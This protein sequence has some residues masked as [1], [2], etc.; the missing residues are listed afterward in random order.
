MEELRNWLG[1]RGLDAEAVNT[2]RR[3]HDQ[4]L[5][6]IENEHQF[7]SHLQVT[8]QT[9]LNQSCRRPEDF[10]A[11]KKDLDKINASLASQASEANMR[12]NKRSKRCSKENL[13]RRP[14]PPTIRSRA[15][16]S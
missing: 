1:S 16:Y 7:P 6:Y 11:A 3:N 14:P 15:C 9:I 2:L 8:V 5:Q 13:Y 12:L 10:F 4:R